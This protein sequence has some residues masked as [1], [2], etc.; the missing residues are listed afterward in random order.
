MWERLTETGAFEE[1]EDP[2]VWI[3]PI[4]SS[5][6]QI[7]ADYDK[8]VMPWRGSALEQPA[9]LMQA[10]R[11]HKRAIRRTQDVIAER[12]RFNQRGRDGK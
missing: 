3:L 8:G 1:E 9:R 5:I 10:I 7:A 2:Y 6:D 12:E 11:L 4:L